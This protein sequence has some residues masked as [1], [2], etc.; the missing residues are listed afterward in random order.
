[1]LK[2]GLK[3]I[4]TN[5]NR[6]IV[7]KNKKNQRHKMC[8]CISIIKASFKGAVLCLQMQN[9]LKITMRLVLA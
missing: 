5:V 7:K 1:M 3:S 2:T 6:K 4:M 8:D 9:N